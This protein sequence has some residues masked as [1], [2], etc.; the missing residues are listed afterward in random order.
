[1]KR[2]LS[3]V[4]RFDFKRLLLVSFSVFGAIWTAA[5]SSS[6]FIAPFK[7]ADYGVKG[8]LFIVCMSLVVALGVELYLTRFREIVI[9]EFGK[10]LIY[11]PLYL[12]I[13]L[14]LFEKQGLRV[15]LID[16]LGDEPTWKKVA[17]GDAQFG[18][19]DPF[20]MIRDPTI[21]GVIVATVVGR[22]AFWGVSKKPIA[23]SLDIEQIATL[24]SSVYRSPSTQHALLMNAMVGHQ[25]D[26]PRIHQHAP[27]S[28]MAPLQNPEVDIVWLLEPFAT[29]AERTGAKY[30][31]SGPKLFGEFLFTGCYCT[32]KYASENPEV[33]Q[34]VVAA[35]QAA[36]EVIH[37]DHLAVLNV[38]HQEFPTL[39]K[40]KAE[41]ATLRMIDEAIFPQNVAVDEDAWHKALAV[42]FPDTWQ[43]HSFVDYV[44]NRF[45]EAAVP[46]RH[47]R[48]WGNL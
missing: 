44:D 16:G 22:A 32:R 38:V 11:L 12:A 30:V 36:Y 24:C 46:R 43:N 20:G 2:L 35:L 4:R 23:P 37:D 26:K 9:C 3:R 33:V 19:S 17:S 28:E 25:A 10:A 45:A 1:M 40:T 13:R 5:E 7:L 31:F 34:A 42:W 48:G 18:V 6:A 15:K 27:G 21:A 47:P 14:K 29:V 39:H 8:Y 41:L